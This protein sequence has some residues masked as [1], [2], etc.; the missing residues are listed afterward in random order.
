MVACDAPCMNPSV[1]KHKPGLSSLLRATL[2]AACAVS[3]LSFGV[4]AAFGLLTGPLPSDLGITR[5]AYSSAIAIQN[6]CWGMAQPF[7][8]MLTDRF[9]ARRVLIG[10]ALLYAAGIAWL[11]VAS[12]AVE[13]LLSAGLLTGIG[14]GFASF[15]M[16]VAA[17]GRAMPESH[18]GWAMGLGTAAG[19]LGQF[20]V[21]PVTQA[22]INSGGW[23][24]GGWF[25]SAA[26]ASMVLIAWFVRGDSPP[27][28]TVVRSRTQ[29]VLAAAFRHPSYVLLVAGFFVCGFQLAFIGTHL[30]SYLADKGM[31]PT[32]ASWALAIVGL[33]NVVGAYASGVA[34]A[35]ISK[36]NLL[37]AIYFGRAFLITVFITIPPS[38]PSVLFFGAGMGVLWLSTVPLTSGLVVT[39][40]GTQ[41][42]ATLFGLAFLSHQVG[43]FL[44]VYLGGVLFEQTGSYDLV[45]YACIALSIS[46]AVLNLP[47]L[48]RPSQRFREIAYS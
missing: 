47:I 9:G 40:F 39:F 37:A 42:M 5:E 26:A 22:V 24:A 48:E 15:T 23:R 12:T 35:R 3:L 19:S 45:W 29:D 32:V 30:A 34:G 13:V 16:A 36:K 14:I 46:A 20:V 7:A 11:C 8:G 38:L 25:L 41:Y 6:L 31:S 43:S 21:V 27:V 10:G 17:L 2:L 44:G 28:G 33:T 4:R 18:R 1:Y